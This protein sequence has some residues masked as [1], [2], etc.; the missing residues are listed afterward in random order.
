MLFKLVEILFMAKSPFLNF[1]L[2][3]DALNVDHFE[4]ERNCLIVVPKS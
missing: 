3:F 1:E 2:T 4:A